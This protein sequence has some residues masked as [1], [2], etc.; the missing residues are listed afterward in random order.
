[1]RGFLPK[2]VYE[3][4]SEIGNFFRQLCSRTL[5]KEVMKK[6]KQDIPLI[7]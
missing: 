4:V 7:L 3:A 2:D 1:L 5:R 6:L